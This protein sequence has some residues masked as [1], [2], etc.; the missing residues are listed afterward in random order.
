M[1]SKYFGVPSIESVMAGFA[2]GIK[3]MKEIADHHTQQSIAKRAYAERMQEEMEEA[4]GDSVAA[5]NEAMRATNAAK[6]LEAFVEGIIGK[7][8]AE[9]SESSAAF[10]Q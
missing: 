10:A 4:L 1:L 9:G 5:E 8:G 2:A 6:R 7:D 3:Q